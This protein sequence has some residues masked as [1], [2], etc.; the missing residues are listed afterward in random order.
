[1]DKQ[2]KTEAKQNLFR[3]RNIEED[4]LRLKKSMNQEFASIRSNTSHEINQQRT[5]ID[6]QRQELEEWWRIMKRPN[7]DL[8]KVSSLSNSNQV[9]QLTASLDA[10][11]A[12]VR[13]ANITVSG[14][15]ENKLVDAPLT[16]LLEMIRKVLPDFREQ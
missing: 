4:I 6:E 10:V 16:T 5:L 2:F 8:I 14:F 15:D 12:R 7:M 1:M 3:C 13:A 11:D 9:N